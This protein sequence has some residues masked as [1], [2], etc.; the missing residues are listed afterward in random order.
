MPVFLR[1][2]GRSAT[3]RTNHQRR[4]H[5]NQHEQ[6][7]TDDRAVP[8]QVVLEPRHDHEHRDGEQTRTSVL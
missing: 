1:I 3:A 7:Q 6:H 5:Q 4:Q 8:P 2:S